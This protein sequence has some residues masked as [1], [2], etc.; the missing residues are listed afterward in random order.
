MTP[1]RPC[2]FGPTMT[3]ASFCFQMG[4]SVFFLSFFFGRLGWALTP[5]G[6][7]RREGWDVEEVKQKSGIIKSGHSSLESGDLHF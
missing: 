5:R 4:H 6:K 3:A 1:T 2:C 7:L